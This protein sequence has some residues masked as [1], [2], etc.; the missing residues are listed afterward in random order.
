MT[1]IPTD[2]RNLTIERS[3]PTAAED[4]ARADI[5]RRIAR[6]F[7]DDVLAWRAVEAFWPAW[8]HQFLDATSRS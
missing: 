5:E 3:A 6:E 2:G 1:T 8:R 4:A 7:G